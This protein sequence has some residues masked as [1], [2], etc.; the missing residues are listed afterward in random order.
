MIPITVSP[1]MGITIGTGGT[2]VSYT[3]G[4]SAILLSPLT[5]KN[6]HYRSSLL[7]SFITVIGDNGIGDKPTV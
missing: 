1:I 6:D 3:V 5:V 7:R 2:S 4:L